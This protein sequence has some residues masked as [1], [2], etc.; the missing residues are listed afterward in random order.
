MGHFSGGCDEVFAFAVAGKAGANAE[1]GFAEAGAAA[2]AGGGGDGS[3]TWVRGGGILTTGAACCRASFLLIKISQP[4][5]FSCN[6]AI[7][8]ESTSLLIKK[9]TNFSKKDV[10]CMYETV[11]NTG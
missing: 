9:N 2:V 1:G 5:C 11:N 10:S 8:L 7:S 4:N 6:S 3:V